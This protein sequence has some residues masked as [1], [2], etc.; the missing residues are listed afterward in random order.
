[1]SLLRFTIK[2][3]TFCWENNAIRQKPIRVNFVTLITLSFLIWLL[4]LLEDFTGLMV[5]LYWKIIVY[6]VNSSHEGSILGFSTWNYNQMGTTN[7]VIVP[8][9]YH[10]P[11]YPE[12][13]VYQDAYMYSK[14]VWSCVSWSI[15]R[16]FD[17]NWTF[18]V[19]LTFYRDQGLSLGY[20]GSSPGLR[21]KSLR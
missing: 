17:Q 12:K 8:C 1:M 2:T 16:I 13:H 14:H 7:L 4:A 10:V 20:L 19:E 18:S 5:I 21:G 15:T 9:L 6:T 11:M 3:Y